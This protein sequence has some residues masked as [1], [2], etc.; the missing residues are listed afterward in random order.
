MRKILAAAGALC[1]AAAI[2]GSS[3]TAASAATSHA[4][5]TEF[6]RFVS[7]LPSGRASA[8]ATGAFTAGGSI[9]LNTRVG[10]LR[11]PGGTFKAYPRPTHTVSQVNR[12]TCLLT[13][14][15]RGRYR[16]GKGTGKFRHIKGHGTFTADILGVL[17]R[18]K[19]GKCS[20]SAPPLAL[21]QVVTAH[22]PVS[23]V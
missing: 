8:I 9:N 19:K 6:F 16:I 7:G 15:Q 21:Q 10:T 12:H 22:G 14:L 4:G 5:R 20:E 2:T 18:N 3:L 11:F 1:A 23:G 17:R 13:V